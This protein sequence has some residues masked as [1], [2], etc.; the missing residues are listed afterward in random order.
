MRNF[1]AFMAAL[2]VVFLG[3]GWYLGWYNVL[4]QPSGPGHSRLEVDI[5]KDKIGQD[6]QQGVKKGS[7]KVQELLDKNK[8]TPAS[9]TEE[10]PSSSLLPPPPGSQAAAGNQ[11]AKPAEKSEEKFRDFIIDGWLSGPKK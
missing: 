5:N 10:K 9:G 6:V 8:Q 7:E 4:L 3:L 2:V 11:V 1:L